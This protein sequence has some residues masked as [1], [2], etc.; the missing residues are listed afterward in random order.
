MIT[1]RKYGAPVDTSLPS[2]SHAS[3]RPTISGGVF[4]CPMLAISPESRPAYA[5]ELAARA[6]ASIAGPL[7]FASA[8]KGKNSEDPSVE[9]QF[10]RELSS[11]R[12]SR[13][14]APLALVVYD[15]RVDGL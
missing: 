6:L 15:S 5:V 10:D 11:R 9:E 8:N 14:V 12:R 7:P 1:I 2:A 4:L 13:L 3:F